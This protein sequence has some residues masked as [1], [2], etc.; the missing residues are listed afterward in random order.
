MVKWLP[1]L[2]VGGYLLLNLLIR[3]IGVLL[4]AQ[5]WFNALV[6]LGVVASVNATAIV[7][8]RG[9]AHLEMK[10]WTPTFVVAGYLLL[11]MLLGDT[12]LGVLFVPT[13]FAAI[14]VLN[15]LPGGQSWGT[16]SG[17]LS[18]APSLLGWFVSSIIILIIVAIVNGAAIRI[19]HSSGTI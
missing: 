9:R 10:A 13:W 2:V 4:N 3:D 14:L 16:A 6:K 8:L 11:G 15:F 1:T 19:R 12:I 17:A 7:M 5:S 18:L